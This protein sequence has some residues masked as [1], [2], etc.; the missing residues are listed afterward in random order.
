MHTFLFLIPREVLLFHSRFDM[1]QAPSLIGFNDINKQ[2]SELKNTVPCQKKCDIYFRTGD[3]YQLS[4]KQG[5]GPTALPEVR[6]LQK[7][8]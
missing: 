7:D 6:S 8:K 1:K 5:N 3:Q 4:A 2:A